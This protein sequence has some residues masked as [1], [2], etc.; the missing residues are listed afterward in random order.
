[1]NKLLQ[2]ALIDID[3]YKDRPGYP[4]HWKRSSRAKLVALGL[5]VRPISKWDGK[6]HP[7]YFLTQSGKEALAWIL[8]SRPS[9]KNTRI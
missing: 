1:M 5:V 9:K 8:A 6:E 7:C 4:E 3:H 2:A